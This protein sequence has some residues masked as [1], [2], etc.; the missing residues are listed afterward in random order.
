MYRRA[1]LRAA[2]RLLG[3]S[4]PTRKLHYGSGRYRNRV[5]GKPGVNLIG[6]AFAESGIGEHL[7]LAA[8]AVRTAGL[9]FSVCDY[10]KT[11]H[12]QSDESLRD[13]ID[14]SC[15]YAANVFCLN[16]DCVL[17]LW[18]ERRHLFRNRYN[19][20][21]GFWELA[22]YP[23]S[24]LHA[25]N[26]LDEI[27]APSRH[28]QL[29]LSDRASLPVV[30]MSMAVDFPMPRPAQR[31]DFEIPHD[32]FVF[33]ASFDYSSRIERKNP[34]AVVEAFRRAFPPERRDVT[35]VFKTK[36]V[37]G[38]ERQATD[39]AV[40]E[41]LVAADPRVRLVPQT[42][43]REEMLGLIACCDVYV[44]LH[45]AEGFGLG[46]AEAM[47]MGKPT[48]GTNYSGN[49]DFMTPRNS[50]LVDFTLVEAPVGASYNEEESSVWAE[51]DVDQ[52]AGFMTRLVADP[53]W[54]GRLG[55]EAKRHVEAR[56]SFRVIGER[57]RERLEL[58]GLLDRRE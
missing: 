56:H 37:P 52:A 42:L 49:L 3:R 41:R 28:V 26:V 51:A 50:C 7:R 33:L 54:A 34:M 14:P 30:H 17:D 12:R 23:P 40:M 6:F 19:I 45:R 43:T 57:Y 16:N 10:G 1:V 25:M 36:I 2:R 5:S 15:P 20:G 8:G 58:I 29:T 13:L 53:D 9:P 46:L 22:H 44:S 18:Q 11:L 38:V 31:Q 4:Y 21:Y 55:V 35:L 39:A 48:I 24:W 27:W 47:K 32:A